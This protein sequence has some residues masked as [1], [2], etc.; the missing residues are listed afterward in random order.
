MDRTNF[1]KLSRL[2]L[3]GLVAIALSSCTLFKKRQ[4]AGSAALTGG[5]SDPVL[6]LYIWADYTSPQIIEEFTRRTGIKVRVS[7]Y[8]SNEELMA[9]LQAGAIGYD[10][11]LP[12]DYMVPAMIKLGMVRELDKSKIPNLRKV[13]S[14]FLGKDFDPDNKWSLPYAWTITGIGVNT[15]AYP[16]PV[17][18]WEDLL[19]NDKIKDR[20]TVLDDFREAIGAA[21]KLNGASL[22][23]RDP[24]ELAQAKS[25]LIATKPRLKAFNASPA[26][27]LASGEVAMAHIYSGEALVAARD[28]GKAINFIIPKEGG[29]LAID[30]MVIPIGA[31]HIEAAYQFINYL[32]DPSTNADFVRRMMY[33]PVVIGTRAL[34]PIE[35][36]RHPILFPQAEALS[37]CETMKDLG[38]ATS[39]YDRIWSEIKASGH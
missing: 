13:D 39:S 5:K 27:L 29:T 30:N 23:S 9:K 25:T 11:V 38:E 32:Y 6:N 7:N 19:R 31:T 4:D 14:K 20:A 36:Q 16:A 12:T 34:L 26:S 22:N 35:L 2:L 3:T 18:S 17:T 33:G 21:L 28:S 1:K 10:L 8:A 24:K 37:H 15:A